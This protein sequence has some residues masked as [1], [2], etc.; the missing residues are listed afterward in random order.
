MQ[1]IGGY[2]ELELRK[3]H[4]YHQDALRLNT[5]RNCLEYI[6]RAK[7][8][9][10]I[11]IPYYTCE[12]VLEPIKKCAVEYE[13]YTIN[14]QLEPKQEIESLDNE[15]FLYTNYFGVKND[16]VI[17]LA[18]VYKDRLIID[19]SQAFYASPIE[20]IDTFYSARKFFGVADGAYLYTKNKL[21]AKLD[22]DESYKRMSHL[23][24]RIDIGA[25][26]GYNDSK[27]NN[28]SLIGQPI[29]RM[30]LLTERI[31][32]S[33]DYQNIKNIRKRNYIY[34]DTILKDKN[35]LKFE[36]KNEDIP[37]VYP[38][39][40]KT[41]ELKQILIQ[42]KIFVATYWP[43]VLKWREE[44][45]TEYYLTKYIIPLPLDQRYN[46]NDIKYIINIINRESWIL[47]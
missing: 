6:L 29:K 28:N 18:S 44:L 10:K 45:E 22:R 23:L 30:S 34:L 7:H 1:P 40:S 24:K 27:I 8:Y 19:N 13:F 17:K 38:F 20:G 37:L 4:H 12:A 39:F 42:N 46:N 26:A 21:E 33:I 31:L 16:T 32:E 2:F 47:K 25:E 9:K 5:A 3:G 14:E 15:A 35:Q 41:K 43:N 11:Y 36:L